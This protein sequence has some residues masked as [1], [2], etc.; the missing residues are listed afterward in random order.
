M[1]STVE[2]KSAVKNLTAAVADSRQKPETLNPNKHNGI[3]PVRKIPRNPLRN[4]SN[5]SGLRDPHDPLGRCNLSLNSS[6]P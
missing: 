5:P 4:P 6:T 1:L 2:S 3:L